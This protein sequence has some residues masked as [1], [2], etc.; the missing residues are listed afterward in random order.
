MS[1]LYQG[2]EIENLMSSKSLLRNTQFLSS[3]YVRGVTWLILGF[4]QRGFLVIFEIFSTFL[5]ANDTVE[6]K[7]FQ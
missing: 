5:K 1:C 7:L 2:Y 6:A 4:W 3:L